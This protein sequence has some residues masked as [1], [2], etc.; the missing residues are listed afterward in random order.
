M[1]LGAWKYDDDIKINIKE[2]G[3][4]FVDW[5]CLAHNGGQ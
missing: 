2:N 4:E 1:P 5:I 3:W